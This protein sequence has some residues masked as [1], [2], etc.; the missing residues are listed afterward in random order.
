VRACVRAAAHTEQ[1]ANP[2][3]IRAALPSD[4][5]GTCIRARR[6]DVLCVVRQ[7]RSVSMNYPPQRFKRKGG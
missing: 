6:A 2:D 4:R 3:G 1:C 5:A 7:R